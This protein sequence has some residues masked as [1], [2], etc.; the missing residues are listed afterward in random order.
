MVS[1]PVAD[2]GAL[3]AADFS[4]IADAEP[5]VEVLLFGTGARTAFV[6]PSFKAQIKA[7]AGVAVEPMETGAACRT[8][9]ILL[10]EG[11]RVAAALLPL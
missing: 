5:A 7:T 10:A 11:R 2:L 4:L 6:K 8:Y 3:S 1:W 9:N